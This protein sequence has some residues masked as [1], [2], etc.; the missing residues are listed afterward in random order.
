MEISNVTQGTIITSAGQSYMA[1]RTTITVLG[2]TFTQRQILTGG[3]AGLL[4]FLLGRG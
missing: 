1:D 2:I 3:I 4:G